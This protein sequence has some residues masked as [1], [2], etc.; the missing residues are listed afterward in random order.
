MTF[1]HLRISYKYTKSI[2]IIFILLN[3]SIIKYLRNLKE[4]FGIINSSGEQLLSLIEDTGST[5]ASNELE[6]L[7]EPFLQHTIQH[8]VT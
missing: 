6:G 8:K 3:K 2:T 7:F 5:I 1:I 4:N